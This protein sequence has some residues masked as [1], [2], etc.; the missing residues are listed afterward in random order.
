[1]PFRYAL[2]LVFRILVF[3]SQIGPQPHCSENIQNT[4]DFGAVFSRLN[5]DQP[6]ARDTSL[7]C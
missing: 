6:L 2:I 5:L 4:A 3:R 7:V 1:M